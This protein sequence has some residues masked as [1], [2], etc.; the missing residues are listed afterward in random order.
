[1]YN[2][3]G[4]MHRTCGIFC[5]LFVAAALQ[6][7]AT[8]P[9]TAV[10]TGLQLD[11]FNSGSSS[12]LIFNTGG[13]YAC[14]EAV[15][16]IGR[17]GADKNEVGWTLRDTGYAASAPAILVV[18]PGRYHLNGASCLK[19]GYVPARLSAVRLWFG[20]IDVK[21]GE[22]IY[23]GTLNVDVV[24]F[25]TRFDGATRVLNALFLTGRDGLE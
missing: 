9:K 23:I 25:K 14:D 19:Q 1:M 8:T 6:G 16:G 24:E 20:S 15:F 3:G 21:P 2:V 7:C 12:I 5:A 22:V 13:T 4:N 17:E 18:P 11:A 10:P